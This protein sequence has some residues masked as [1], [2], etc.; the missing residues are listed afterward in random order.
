MEINMKKIML[1][2][3]LALCELSVRGSEF[4]DKDFEN[5]SNFCEKIKTSYG[6]ENIRQIDN[7]LEEVVRYVRENFQ[8]NQIDTIIIQYIQAIHYL[9][10]IATNIRRDCR[11]NLAI[12]VINQNDID[13]DTVESYLGAF[14]DFRKIFQLSK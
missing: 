10:N 8:K 14:E 11:V 2:C 12:P 7:D 1:I 9:S 5:Y 13:S 4:D 6:E 3:L